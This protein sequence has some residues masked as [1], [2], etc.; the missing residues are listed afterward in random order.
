MGNN[1]KIVYRQR[2]ATSVDFIEAFPLLCADRGFNCRLERQTWTSDLAGSEIQAL[3]QYSV[4]E[5]NP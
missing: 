4:R 2:R 5:L 3:R 1:P